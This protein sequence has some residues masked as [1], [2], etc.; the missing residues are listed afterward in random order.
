MLQ[1]F[2]P[3]FLSILTLIGM[4]LASYHVLRYKRDTHS[5]SGWLALILASPLVGV[6]LYFI[7]GINRIQRKAKRKKRYHLEL[8]ANAHFNSQFRIENLSKNMTRL[9]NMVKTLTGRDLCPGNQITPLTAEDIA[10][11][12]MLLA[13]NQAKKSVSLCTYI[14]DYDE[15]GQRFLEALVNAQKRGVA[16]RILIDAIGAKYSVPP[17]TPFL[18]TN[19]LK[20][21]LFMPSK[22]PWR[23]RFFNLRNHRK[24]MVI[25]G[26]LG[27]TGGMNIHSGPT[28]ANPY[29]PIVKDLHFKIIGPL[30][31]DL[32]ETFATDWYFSTDEQLKGELWFPYL[33]P[34]GTVI[35]RAIADGPDEDFEHI[36][37]TI[38]GAIVSAE[39]SIVVVTPYFLP[40]SNLVSLLS[41]ASLRGVKVSIVVPENNNIKL[42]AWASKPNMRTLL[43]NG[44]HIFS[45]FPHF[46]H[47]K[48]MIVDKRWVLLGSANW[49]PRSLRLNFEFNVESY[50]EDL[51]EKLS[52]LVD[53][54]INNADE[55]TLKILAKQPLW[56]QIRNRFFNLFS[57]YL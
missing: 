9:A 47:S 2:W 14:F 33:S 17:M 37:K 19:G 5:A 56:M 6:I 38:M 53:K 11:E 55:I 50:D 51:G 42:I 57:P 3:H 28:K 20:T 39:E 29:T 52:Q 13:I 44:I 40:D 54:K 46:D 4:L 8:E 30:V 48:L 32:Q 22:Y 45:S 31:R 15:V 36:K 12:D 21:A 27:F 34:K 1:K 16:I 18:E 23:F 25:D 35:A 26:E 24:I 41:I 49:D 43:E 7:F 10:F